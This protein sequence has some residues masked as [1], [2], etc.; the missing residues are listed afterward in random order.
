[1]VLR[2]RGYVVRVAGGGKEA[3][4][5]LREEPVDLVVLD[6]LMPGISGWDVIQEMEV[7]FQGKPSPP[8]LVILSA[9]SRYE[10]E[11][12]L[13]E[14]RYPVAKYVEKPFSLDRFLRVV[15]GIFERNNGY[16]VK[17]PSERP[18]E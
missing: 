17:K 4:A 11:K 10:S 18:G 1:M 3:L 13:K 5:I 2:E 12:R 6:L 8:K 9:V 14:I 15:K 7:L 16:H